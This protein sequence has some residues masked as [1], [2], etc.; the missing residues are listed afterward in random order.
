[1]LGDS[2]MTNEPKMLRTLKSHP[3]IHPVYQI[4]KW[5][6]FE[7]DETIDGSDRRK[8]LFIR[9][10]SG[11]PTVLSRKI[12]KG[13]MKQ[14]D[15][16]KN[17]FDFDSA[18][19]ILRSRNTFYYAVDIDKGQ[20]TLKEPSEPFVPSLRFKILKKGLVSQLVSGLDTKGFAEMLI[21]ILL[22][23]AAFGFMGYIIGNVLP[24]G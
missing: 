3:E 23:G 10:M 22:A 5:K 12:V 8:V 2:L 4:A 20:M 6:S 21:Y 11:I 7:S 17:N 15:Y 13:R 19:P 1:M 24:I 9:S 16:V 14:I 18:K